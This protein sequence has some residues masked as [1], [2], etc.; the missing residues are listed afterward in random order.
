MISGSGRNLVDKELFIGRFP[1]CTILFLTD[2]MLS[3]VKYNYQNLHHYQKTKLLNSYSTPPPPPPPPGTEEMHAYSPS[4]AKAVFV[5]GGVCSGLRGQPE[6]RPLQV[7][8]RRAARHH[9]HV[10]RHR[11]PRGV[12]VSELQISPQMFRKGKGGYTSL[13]L[14]IVFSLACT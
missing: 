12:Q 7:E 5:G 6:V 1:R 3:I 14:P 11:T 8:V 9:Q 2:N 10:L 4:A 13:F